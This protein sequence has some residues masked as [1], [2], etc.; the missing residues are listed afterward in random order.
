MIDISH[1]RDFCSNA[2]LDNCKV[3]ITIFPFY[4][5]SSTIYH[6]STILGPCFLLDWVAPRVGD[7]TLN[8]I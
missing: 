8:T 4:S 5:Y 6:F 7:V 3:I 1:N 2:P